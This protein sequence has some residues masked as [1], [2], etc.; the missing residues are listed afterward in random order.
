MT[1]L[2][3]L[4]VESRA[5]TVELPGLPE[6]VAHDHGSIVEAIASRR[7]EVAREMMAKHLANVAT[8]A[9]E[10][11][12]PRA[13]NRDSP[14]RGGHD[15]QKEPKRERLSTKETQTPPDPRADPAKPPTSV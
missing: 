8:A 15:H 10:A 5:M 7:P 14:T 11:A 12:T 2:S 1:S 6:K 4:G 3:S 9:A 13:G